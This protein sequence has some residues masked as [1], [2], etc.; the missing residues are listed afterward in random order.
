MTVKVS[1]QDRGYFAFEFT[2][3][4]DPNWRSIDKSNRRV[5]AMELVERWLRGEVEGVYLG[6]RDAG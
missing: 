2:A 1:E 5:E 4:G 3:D 6:R